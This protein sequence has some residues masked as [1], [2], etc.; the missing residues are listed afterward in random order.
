V[1]GFDYRLPPPGAVIEDGILHASVTYP[2][3]AIRYT[4]DGMEPSTASPLYEGPIAVTGGVR[5]RTFDT[6]GRGSRTTVVGEP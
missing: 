1:G 2:G 4:T 6:R 3:L 5:L